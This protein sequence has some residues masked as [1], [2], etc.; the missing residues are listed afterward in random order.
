MLDTLGRGEA[1]AILLAEEVHAAWIVMDDATGR[2]VAAR[3]GLRIIGTLG[4][5]LAAKRRFE[6]ESL[7]AE[8]DRLLEL[9][10]R[11]S[12]RLVAAVLEEADEA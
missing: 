3:R 5:L 10:F 1:E 9:G 8:I 11:V 6:I 2:R 7:R 12:P 4:I